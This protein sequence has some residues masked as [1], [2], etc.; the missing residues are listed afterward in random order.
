MIPDW[1][2]SGVLPPI[3]PGNPGHSPDRSPYQ[4]TLM[5]I[6][7]RFSYTPERRDILKGLLEYRT[8]LHAAGITKGFQWLDGSFMEVVEVREGR[9]PND[10][11]VVTFF[12]LPD[13]V[14]QLDL[15]SAHASLFNHGHIK[16]TYKVDAY[17]VVLGAVFDSLHVK[18]LSYWYSMWSHTRQAQW[19]GF[20]QIDLSPEHDKEAE[21]LLLAGMVEEVD[22]EQ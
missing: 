11:D 17:P 10:V 20:L 15:A 6:V 12:H 22:D 14:S 5:D 16:V 18:Q 1:N 4:T 2:I 21:S 13:G 3:R 19:K 9:A 8:A 7:D